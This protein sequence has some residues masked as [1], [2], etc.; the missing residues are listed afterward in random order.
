MEPIPYDGIPP[1]A[2]MRKRVLVLAQLNVPSFV[3]SIWETIPFGWRGW[4]AM[5]AG[6]WDVRRRDRKEKCGW[7]VA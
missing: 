4:G 5:L 7:N 1:S 6:R 2:L 3:D